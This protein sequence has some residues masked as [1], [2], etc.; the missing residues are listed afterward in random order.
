MPTYQFDLSA[1]CSFNCLLACLICVYSVFSIH[2]LNVLFS[3]YVHRDHAK[4]WAIPSY[5]GNQ[6][7]AVNPS[8]S[9]KPSRSLPTKYSTEVDTSMRVVPMDEDDEEVLDGAA[10]TLSWKGKGKRE[11]KLTPPQT[12]GKMFNIQVRPTLSSC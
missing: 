1:A 4:L 8:P 11:K 10:A 12:T 2:G 7:E 3:R 5:H 6:P 9:A